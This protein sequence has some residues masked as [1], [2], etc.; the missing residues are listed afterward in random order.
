[1]TIIPVI[2]TNEKSLLPNKPPAP[3]PY[4]SFVIFT[5][6]DDVIRQPWQPWHPLFI[7]YDYFFISFIGLFLLGEGGDYI[8]TK[9]EFIE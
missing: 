7:D 5:F 6:C 2:F 8:H 9:Y 3:T 4:K 1:M